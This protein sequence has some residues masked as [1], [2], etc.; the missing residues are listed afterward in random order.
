LITFVVVGNDEENKQVHG[1]LVQV[2][3]M[4]PVLACK[5]RAHDMQVLVH[6]M[7]ALACRVLLHDM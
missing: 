7:Q 3:D 2:H 1:M 4:V 5:V 6:G